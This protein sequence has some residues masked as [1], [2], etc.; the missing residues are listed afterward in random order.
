MIELQRDKRSFFRLEEISFR[1]RSGP[2]LWKDLFAFLPR[3]YGNSDLSRWI[4][5]KTAV[6]HGLRFMLKWILYR[7]VV[8]YESLIIRF[9]RDQMNSG[10]CR[11]F[12]IHS[13]VARSRNISRSKWFS[14]MLTSDKGNNIDQRKRIHFDRITPLS[15]LHE[16]PRAD[17]W[18]TNLCVNFLLMEKFFSLMT[19]HSMRRDWCSSSMWTEQP[20]KDASHLY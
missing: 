4:N 8:K 19:Y 6:S 17:S 9:C 11:M 10:C 3:I 15:H 20:K 14:S 5:L 13:P 1:L 7:G 2:G 18:M 16:L 12:R